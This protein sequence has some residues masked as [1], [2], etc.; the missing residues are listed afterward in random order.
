MSLPRVS[1]IIPTYNRAHL[2]PEA[3]DSVLAQTFQDVEI[4]V[5]DDGSTDTTAAVVAQY[6]TQVRYVVGTHRGAAGA[7]ARNLG[8]SYARGE[9]IGF[10]DSDDHWLPHKLTQQMVLLDANHDCRWCYTDAVAF[11]GATG[12]VM[13]RYSE[14][15]TMAQ[16]DVLVP[17]FRGN[18]IPSITPLFHRD[19][20]EN[21]GTFWPTPK[22]TDWDMML[23]V[24]AQY[25]LT[26]L[27]EV[28]AEVRLHRQRVTD[29]AQGMA[30]YD[31]GVQVLQRAVE[32][33]P[34]RLRPVYRTAHAKLCLR[35]GLWSA[36]QGDLAAART[37]FARSV[38][39]EPG[40]RPI[41]YWLATW[42]GNRLLQRAAHARQ[43]DRQ[44]RSKL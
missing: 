10:L 2:L 13:Y 25:E 4:I 7:H 31:A 28:T 26:Y 36:R 44:R 6:G 1:V 5:A 33:N 32:R 14:T 42:G 35:S 8:L 19:V 30:A 12:D 17:L 20:F 22:L 38:R 18:F 11:D 34:Q 37:L 40:F 29:A 9:F 43:R 3:I 15:H 41:F 39:L 27:P 23:R 16:G 21:V 24:A